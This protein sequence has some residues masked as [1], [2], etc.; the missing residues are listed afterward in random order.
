MAVPAIPGVKLYTL[1]VPAESLSN[2]NGAG[3]LI[4]ATDEGTIAIPADMLKG[5]TGT[6]G[7]TAGITIGPGDKT[8]LSAEAAAAVG[9]RPLV[10]L[11]LALNGM[12]TSWNN[13]SAP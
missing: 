12:Q 6:E 5:M 7:K 1:E 13:S 8:G 9:G 2:S 11:T 10:E 4:F 3:E